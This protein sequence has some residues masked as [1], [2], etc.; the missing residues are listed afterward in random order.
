[1]ILR[2]DRIKIGLETAIISYFCSVKIGLSVYK[3]VFGLKSRK[4][5]LFTDSMFKI[6]LRISSEL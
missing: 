5:A 3:I 2:N 6:V 4:F 1:M